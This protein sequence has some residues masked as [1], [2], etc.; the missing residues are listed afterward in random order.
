MATSIT[1]RIVNLTATVT[2]APTPSQLQQS[3]A[4]VSV[5]GTT[6][7]S[8]TYQ[9][10]ASPNA[11]ITSLLSGSGNSTELQTMANTFSAQGNSLGAYVLELG[12][13]SGVV[14]T[15]ISTLQT[16]IAAN[17]NEFYAYLTPESWDYSKDE[18]GS[19]SI[20]SGGSGYTSAPSV[21]FSAPASGTTASGTAVVQNGE[22]VQVNITAPGNGYTAAPTVTF[23]GGGGTGATATA[24]LASALNILASEYASPTSKTYF[25]ATTTQA[26]VANYSN[27]KSVIAFVPSPNATSQEFGAAALFYQLLVNNPSQANPMGPM[28][29]RYV[30]GVTPWPSSGVSSQ[31]TAILSAYGNLVQQGT[32][33]GITNSCIF[34]GTTMDGNQISWWYGIDWFQ[35]NVNQTLAATVI[36]GSNTI[37]PLVYDQNGINTLQKAAQQVGNNGVQFQCL[38]SATVSATPFSTYTTQNPNDYAAGIYSGLS[39]VAVGQNGFLELNFALDAQTFA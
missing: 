16:W 19:V 24:A 2:Q 14:D 9:F 36:N 10:L 12:A 30:Y 20:T 15:Q 39:A 3:G 21:A 17:P 25:V 29:Y 11:D 5:G 37:P 35:I 1:N 22:V 27:Q 31:T 28:S 38:L 8:G 26:N 18:V 33:A 4:L 6:L 7:T 34:K 23:S 13:S 32:Q